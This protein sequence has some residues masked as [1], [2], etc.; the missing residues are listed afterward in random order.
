MRKLWE[1]MYKKETAFTRESSLVNMH[2]FLTFKAETLKRGCNTRIT[3]SK[4]PNFAPKLTP[5]L[6]N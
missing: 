4:T 3:T 6:S 2:K 5:K 1:D